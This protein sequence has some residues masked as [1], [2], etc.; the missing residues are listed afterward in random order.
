MADFSGVALLTLSGDEDVD[1]FEHKLNKIS[2]F[3][4]S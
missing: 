3:S 2:Q 1:V 4:L